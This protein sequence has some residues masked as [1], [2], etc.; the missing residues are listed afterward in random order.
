MAFSTLHV[1][2]LSNSLE[3]LH[4]CGEDPQ[5]M[6]SEQ[7]YESELE[8]DIIDGF[9][10]ADAVY[11]A[12]NKIQHFAFYWMKL[13]SDCCIQRGDA[14]NL[15]R[16]GCTEEAV[17][18]LEDWPQTIACPSIPQIIPTAES[19]SL[20]RK[21]PKKRESAEQLVAEM[22]KSFTFDG[23]TVHEDV[24]NILPRQLLSL[25][26]YEAKI[27]ECEVCLQSVENYHLKNAFA[28]GA[29]LQQ[30]FERFQQDKKEEN[31]SVGNFDD[32]IN[33]KCV[34]KSRR[35]RQLRAFY[36][37][38]KGYKRVL[39]CKLP[40]VWFVKNGKDVAQY[41]EEHKDTTSS[42]SHNLDCECSKCETF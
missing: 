25:R 12:N 18:A 17:K 41:L 29:W 15:L 39:N 40:F 19:Q 23:I 22:R 26:E 16:V 20:A 2:N 36:S 24:P 10:L 3:D 5:V 7:G 38:F 35:A 32:W 28:Y 33:V 14:L 1:D 13:Y 42:W 37:L 27:R 11:Q 6:L 34:V 4:L 31:V 8:V 30:A 9:Y 21:K